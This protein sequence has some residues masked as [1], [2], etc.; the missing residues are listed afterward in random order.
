LIII[1]YGLWRRKAL[2]KTVDLIEIYNFSFEIISML[3]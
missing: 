2:Y 1:S 3:K